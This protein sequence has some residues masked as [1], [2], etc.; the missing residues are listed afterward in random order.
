[1]IYDVN[2]LLLLAVQYNACIGACS[3][4]Y[5]EQKDGEQRGVSPA[6]KHDTEGDAKH[7]RERVQT[8][9]RSEHLAYEQK[10]TTSQQLA[11]ASPS[12]WLLWRQMFHRWTC[13]H[14][15][16]TSIAATRHTS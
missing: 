15:Y 11:T 14:S 8:A 3:A 1:M 7:V 13:T 5:G 6:R 4:A 10:T 16:D 2:M 9:V 12:C